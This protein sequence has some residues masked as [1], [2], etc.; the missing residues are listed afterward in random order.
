VICSKIK[1]TK[2][3]NLENL[4]LTVRTW[5]ENAKAGNLI[6]E[7]TLSSPSLWV[8]GTLSHCGLINVAW[9]W[10]WCL[11]P[12]SYSGG[13]D[14]KDQ[15]CR[16]AWAKVNETSIPTTTKELGLLAA[17]WSHR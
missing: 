15:G 3:L 17:M 4:L 2:K 6:Q 9:R 16:P 10:V 13:R 14:W 8:T 11:T 7:H 5:R 12:P 1:K